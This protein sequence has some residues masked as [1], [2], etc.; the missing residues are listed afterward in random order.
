M[1]AYRKELADFWRDKPKLYALILQHL[2]DES[3]DA[4][5]KEVGW[6]EIEE[7]ADPEGLWQLIELKHKVHSTSQVEAVVKLAARTQLAM[8]R[9]GAFESIVAF[10]Q[11]YTNALKAYKDQK[12]PE[13]LPVDE[14]MDVFSKL[15]NTR[16]A[17]FKMTYLNNLQLK[18]CNPPA[19]LNEIFTL[20]NTYLKPKAATGGGFAST[21]A[22]TVD[23]VDKSRR[24]RGGKGKNDE[25]DKTNNGKQP[26]ASDNGSDDSLSGK[27]RPVKCFYCGEEHYISNCPEFLQFKK[28]KE[29]RDKNATATWDASTFATYQIIAVGKTG[30]ERSDVLLDNQAN[31]SI[32]HPSLLS[33]IEQTEV[34]IRVNG[35]GGVQL[36]TD[37]TG[38]L[39]DFF[40]VYASTD[41]RANVLSFADVEDLYDVTYDKGKSFTVHLPD[42]DIVFYRKKKLY[43][44]DFSHLLNE[45]KAFLA[46]YTKGQEARA[47]AAYDLV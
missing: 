21:F 28:A 20:A 41:T 31:V 3:L 46:T 7:G 38:Y 24:R 17:E 27:K 29:D 6:T 13:L 40:R 18:A 22:T 39:E 47:K 42:R 35:V 45:R 12:N 34:E 5:Q 32:M 33:A 15:D 43:V 1:T 37:R 8:T 26:D 4:V 23:T 30:L 44:A 16:Y 11:R 14:A 10:K 36:V 9:Q 19:D 25:G 2:S